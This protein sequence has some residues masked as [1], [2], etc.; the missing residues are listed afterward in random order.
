MNGP[1]ESAAP[2]RD[3]QVGHI[4]RNMRSAARLPREAIARRL[5]TTPGTIED[6]ENGAV[7]SLPHWRET[8]RIVRSYCELLRLDPQPILW[9]MQSQMHAGGYD[10]PPT[11]S[12]V[13]RP[14]AI[15]RQEPARSR[16]PGRSRRRARR[17]F[18]LSAP[19]VLAAAAFYLAQA[20]PAPIYRAI[21]LLPAPLG[22]AARAG[23]DKLV[24]Y[25]APRREG[26]RWVDVGD[27]QLR[28]VDKLQTSNR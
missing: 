9:R 1:L 7:A 8:T 6:L 10:D 12:P 24:L 11:R 13:T 20:A 15:L 2:G 14:P 19:L 4:F 26:L 28:K 3:V 21:G 22:G 17:M 16:P 18:A 25:S 5:A 27:P 23:M